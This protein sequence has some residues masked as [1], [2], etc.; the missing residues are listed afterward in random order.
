MQYKETTVSFILLHFILRG[1]GHCVHE[2]QNIVVAEFSC[3]SIFDNF[4]GDT[5][6]VV[7]V[8]VK[9]GLFQY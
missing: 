7:V 8:V 5:F 4:S 6:F 3:K 2:I 9:Q 1:S